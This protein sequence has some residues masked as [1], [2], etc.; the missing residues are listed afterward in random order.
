MKWPGSTS[1][2]TALA[3]FPTNKIFI[4]ED[5]RSERECQ[6][7][8]AKVLPELARAIRSHT[9]RPI[10]FPMRIY[11]KDY[12]TTSATRIQKETIPHSCQAFFQEYLE[13]KGFHHVGMFPEDVSD[14]ITHYKIHNM[15]FHTEK[16]D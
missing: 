13:T 11:K 3:E 9:G 12:P 8:V 14:G 7:I 5:T 10:H 6:H 15:R 16:Q 4:Y 1:A 2:T